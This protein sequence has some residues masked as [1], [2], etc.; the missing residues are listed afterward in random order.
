MVYTTPK[1]IS[2]DK[3]LKIYE[4]GLKKIFRPK[5]RKSRRPLTNKK[6]IRIK[7]RERNNGKIYMI[8]LKK[9]IQELMKSKLN[10]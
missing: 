3:I 7:E 1:W 6:K 4:E 8:G 10:H 9:L 5:R 2:E